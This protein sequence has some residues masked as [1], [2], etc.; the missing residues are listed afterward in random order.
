VTNKPRS[1][2]LVNLTCA[3]AMAATVG[4]LYVGAYGAFYR[5][6]CRD[7]INQGGTGDDIGTLVFTP[8]EA[9]TGSEL[10]GSELLRQFTF[11]CCAAGED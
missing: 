8:L 7:V 6:L 2:L 3:V 1:P 5:C 11:W 9:Y 10:P 4:A